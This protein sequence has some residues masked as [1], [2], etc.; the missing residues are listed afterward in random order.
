MTKSNV[1]IYRE[2]NKRK[3]GRGGKDRICLDLHL[4]QTLYRT[5]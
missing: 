3:E 2:V 4:G 5:F 1:S